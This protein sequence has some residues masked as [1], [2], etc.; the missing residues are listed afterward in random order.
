MI[1]KF[2]VLIFLMFVGYLAMAD[3]IQFTMEG[4]EVVA[5]GEQFRLGFTLNEQGTDLQLP[6]LSNFDVLMGPSTSQSS[7]IQIINGKTTQSSMAV[8]SRW[9]RY[10]KLH[11]NQTG[12]RREVRAG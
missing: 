3:N 12:K 11:R 7:S 4:P 1:R 8:V 9:G 6:D 10:P 2:K 5:S